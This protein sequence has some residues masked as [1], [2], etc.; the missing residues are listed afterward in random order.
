MNEQHDRAQRLDILAQLIKCQMMLI[1][2]RLDELQTAP[3]CR[4]TAQ[5]ALSQ[6]RE[7]A[8]L[9]DLLLATTRKSD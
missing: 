8:L 1:D 5:K 9:T 4:E 3:D 7:M 6:V 2:T